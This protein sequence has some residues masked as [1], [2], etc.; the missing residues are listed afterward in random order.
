MADTFVAII[1][2]DGASGTGKGTLCRHLARW[3]G[4][5]LLD[6]GALYRGLAVATEKRAIALD[7]EN[8]IAS[9]ADTLDITFNGAHEEDGM[10]VILEGDDIT[11]QIISEKC[12]N[13]AS[14]IA[15][16]PKVRE[17]LLQ[18]QKNFFQPPGL[19]A[20][21]RDMG[22]IVFAHAALKIYLTATVA[23]R[24]KRRYKQLKC[25]AVNVSLSQVTEYI[26]ERDIRDSQRFISPMKPAEDAIIIDT[27]IGIVALQ[28][29]IEILVRSVL[30]DTYITP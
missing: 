30:P 25:K 23:E 27:R 15:V 16:L 6:S 20:D 22:T 28:K 8:A 18:R 9:L 10:T 7:N 19:I 2:V 29:K 3:L 24:A 5:N 1:T 11:Q 4:W 14:Q 26:E 17:A 13:S 12:A 21:G